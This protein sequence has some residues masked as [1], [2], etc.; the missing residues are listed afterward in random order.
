MEKNIDE[1]FKLLDV[2]MEEN[3]IPKDKQIMYYKNLILTLE[4][5]KYFLKQKLI[6]FTTG[7]IALSSAFSI[8]LLSSESIDITFSVF[9][10]L[11]GVII[12]TI[13]FSQNEN[14]YLKEYEEIEN[15]RQIYKII[16][17]K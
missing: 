7:G 2:W 14:D 15:Q 1:T 3:K 4:E 17:K 12:G 16:Y 8:L 9:L 11:Y 13:P 10:I 6:C 5:Q